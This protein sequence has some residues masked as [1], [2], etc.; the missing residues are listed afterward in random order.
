MERSVLRCTGGGHFKE[1][2]IVLDGTA[3]T[4]RW[5]KIGGTMQSQ[6]KS[7]T[8]KSAARAYAR[9]KEWEKMQKGYTMYLFIPEEPDRYISPLFKDDIELMQSIEAS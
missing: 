4:V 7:F 1:Y 5:G 9:S 3:V 8:T 6:L 2:E